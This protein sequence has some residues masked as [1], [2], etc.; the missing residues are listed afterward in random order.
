MWTLRVPSSAFASCQVVSSC[1][2]ESLHAIPRDHIVDRLWDRPTSVV[3]LAQLPGNQLRKRSILP[4]ECN[5]Y[6]GG[7]HA[8]WGIRVSVRPARCYQRLSGRGRKNVQKV[9]LDMFTGHTTL[10]LS[11][12]RVHC[13]CA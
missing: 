4:N 9:Q 11:I 7:L 12:P 6:L 8:G 5:S 3:V 13:I 2:S 1:R 10:H